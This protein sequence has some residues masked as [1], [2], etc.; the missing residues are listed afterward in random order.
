MKGVVSQC[1]VQVQKT[2]DHD[3]RI[4]NSSFYK[5]P[6]PPS[7]S[8]SHTHTCM[9]MC[10]PYMYVCMYVCMYFVCCNCSETSQ[11]EHP[12]N[13]NTSSPWARRGFRARSPPPPGSYQTSAILCILGCS[14]RLSMLTLNL[15]GSTPCFPL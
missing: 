5:Y 2:D 1:A 12:E 4:S 10:N 7:L 11:S 9:C 15:L 6:P 3:Y 13:V 8:L 14:L